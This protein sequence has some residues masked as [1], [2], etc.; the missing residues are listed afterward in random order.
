MPESSNC[1]V[2]LLAKDYAAEKTDDVRHA[3]A[4]KETETPDEEKKE[5]VA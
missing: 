3:F 4:K 2:H 5:D 1:N